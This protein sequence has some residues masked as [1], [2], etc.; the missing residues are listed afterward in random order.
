MIF[1]SGG[2]I[3]RIGATMRPS[4]CGTCS[5]ARMGTPRSFMPS[6]SFVTRATTCVEVDGHSAKSF[7]K[8]ADEQRGALGRRVSG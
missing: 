5:D 2:R 6:T 1:T 4:F 8:I 3:S 7:L